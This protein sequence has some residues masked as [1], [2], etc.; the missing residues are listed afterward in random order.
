MKLKGVNLGSWLL[1]EGYI[2]GGRNIAESIF[3]QNFKKANGA[4]ALR[5]FE[6]LFRDNFIKEEDFRN[7]AQMGA[8]C[9]RLPFS[10]RLVSGASDGLIHL[11]KAFTFANKYRLGIILDLHAAPGAQNC[12]W[13]SDSSGRAMFW[14]KEKFRKEALGIW[15]ELVSEFKEEPALIGFDI[16]NEPVLEEKPTDI[17]AEFYKEA[18]KRI[19]A[20]DKKHTIFLE[21]SLWAQRIDFLKD[22][23]E[24]NISISIHTYQP[25]DFTFN[26][27]PFYKFPGKINNEQWDKEKLEKYLEPYFLFSKNNKVPI[28]VGEFGINWRGG[29]WGEINW[30]ESILETFDEF[31]FSYTYWTYKAVSGYVSPDGLYQYIQNSK[32]VVREGPV[33]GWENYITNFKKEK[34]EIVDL[35][36]TKNFT[37][38]DAII[39]KLKEHFKK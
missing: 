22:L 37:P 11:K 13:H 31:N 33:Y 1:M 21:G 27:V 16:I 4:A 3:K 8:N 19:K 18:I 12:D 10:Y 26:F 34:N 5:E 6:R 9:I 24:E 15:D 17:L 38:N 25:L 28:F 14:E 36:Q 30:L 2:L 20:I 35:W 29:F 39:S 23:I 7:I 32:Y